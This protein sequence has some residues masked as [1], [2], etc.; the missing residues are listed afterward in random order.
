MKNLENS[1][2]NKSQ[3]GLN[4]TVDESTYIQVTIEGSN[5]KINI[6]KV[7]TKFK[8][9][10]SAVFQIEINGSVQTVLQHEMPNVIN[11]N[12]TA[13]YSGY[14]YMTN[15][16]GIVLSSTLYRTGNIVAVYL[17]YSC[18]ALDCG[19]LTLDEVVVTGPQAR[20]RYSSAPFGGTSG[21]RYRNRYHSMG[22]AYARH[23]A[24]IELDNRIKANLD[25]IG[26]KPIKEY[27]DKC[28]GLKEAWEKYPKNEVAGFITKDGKSL[29]TDI[30]GYDYSDVAY[31]H[32]LNGENYYIYNANEGSLLLNYEG[33]IRSYEYILIPVTAAFHTH[34]PCRD[35]EGDGISGTVSLHDRNIQEGSNINYWAI[36]CGGAAQYGSGDSFFNTQRGNLQNICAKI[37]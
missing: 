14:V 32:P 15:T 29:I 5:Q 31:I 26:P 37:K 8:T 28:Q 11:K 17:P 23:Y 10:N 33:Q 35:Q 2:S 16:Q 9:L 21:W 30:G 27:D 18:W 1:S 25:D 22:A 12:N 7:D 13:A 4:I 6:A 24:K 36:G 3:N 20:P 19:P 34:A